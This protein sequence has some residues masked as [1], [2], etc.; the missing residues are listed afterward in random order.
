MA[1][2]VFFVKGAKNAIIYDLRN[3]HAILHLLDS[4]AK[5][6]L[7]SL[8]TASDFV[9]RSNDEKRILKFLLKHQLLKHLSKAD[10]V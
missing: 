4:K 10:L 8:L 9:A 6:F 2:K 3:T 7:D 1:E 5:L